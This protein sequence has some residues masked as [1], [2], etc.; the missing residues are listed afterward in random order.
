MKKFSC[1]ISPRVGARLFTFLLVTISMSFAERNVT[2]ASHV[3]LRLPLSFERNQGQA[4]PDVQFL[5]RAG[6]YRLY[7]SKNAAIL[8]VASNK[9]GGS[10][11]V[12]RTNI[13]QMN[14]NA[15]V[16]GIDQQTSTTNYLTGPKSD[17]KVGVPHYR[18]VRYS[19]VY[20]GVDLIYYGT[21]QGLEYDFAVAPHANPSA[22]ALEIEG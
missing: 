4:Q 20:P 10:D 5:A 13:V 8:S 17:W 11:A 15:Q 2:P 22:I 16:S 12:L 6:R 1:Q 18:K 21:T 7:L 9:S 19:A 3:T 14:P